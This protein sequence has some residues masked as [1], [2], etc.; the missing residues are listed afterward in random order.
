MSERPFPHV[1]GVEHRFV[2][3]GGLRMHVAEAG[4]GPPLLLLHGW[5][6][7]WYE[8][9]HQIPALA[10]HYRVIAPDLRG[11]GWTDAPPDG[12]DK[13]TMAADVLALLDA[14]G[15]DRVRLLAHDWGAWIGFIIAVTR[16]ERLERF[17]ALNIPPPWGD[18]DLRGLLGLWRLWYQVVLASPGLGQRAV[19]SHRVM[20]RVLRADNVHDDAFS[21]ADVEEF[22]AALREPARARASQQIY[23]TFLL[24]E[25]MGVATG[26]YG[27]ASLTVPTLLLFGER[28]FAISRRQVARAPRPGDEL[29]I[30]FVPDSG[31]FIAEE[32]PELVVERALEFLGDPAGRREDAPPVRAQP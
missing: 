5:P 17:V 9:R 20:E 6:Q 3:A 11:L 30:E 2:Q 27:K 1:P 19:R 28:D 22:A 18:P 15:L 7:H 23:R 21:D 13:E 4:E 8:W 25:V 31:H 26:R 29:T 10:E 32:K 14:L 24:R 12:Y 16:P